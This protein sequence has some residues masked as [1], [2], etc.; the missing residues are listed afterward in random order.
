MKNFKTNSDPS[1][2]VMVPVATMKDTTG[3]EVVSTT[4]STSQAIASPPP[5]SKQRSLSTAL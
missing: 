3:F 4:S 1:S 5:K 2:Q